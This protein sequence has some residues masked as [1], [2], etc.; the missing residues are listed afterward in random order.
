LELAGVKAMTVI[1]VTAL[2]EWA[3][4]SSFSNLT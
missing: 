4:K 1:D 3:D 2:V